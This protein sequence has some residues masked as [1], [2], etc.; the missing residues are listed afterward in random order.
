MAIDQLAQTMKS[1]ELQEMCQPL[2][3]SSTNVIGIGIRGAR[4]SRI[5]DKCWVCT[6]FALAFCAV[7]YL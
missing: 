3:Y 1:T 4:P 2:I 7:T 5:G 6:I